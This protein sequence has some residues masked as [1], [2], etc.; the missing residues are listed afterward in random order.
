MARWAPLLGRAEPVTPPTCI[1]S[2]FR[3]FQTMSPLH[4]AVGK[5][6]PHLWHRR[7]VV[8]PNVLQLD[9]ISLVLCAAVFPVHRGLR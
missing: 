2:R 6:L 3:R 9:A 7:V 5:R 8:P 1:R 4:G